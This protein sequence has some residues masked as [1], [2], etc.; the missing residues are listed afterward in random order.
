MRTY[1]KVER[2]FLGMAGVYVLFV[3]PNAFADGVMVLRDSGPGA[4]V[5]LA[6]A[7]CLV[8]V[9]S[10]FLFMA[11]RGHAPQWRTRSPR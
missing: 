2:T 6:T 7:L 11:V 9:G 3:S 8:L 4:S 1:T 10:L 5:L